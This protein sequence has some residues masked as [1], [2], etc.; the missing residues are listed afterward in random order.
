MT[1]R[2]RSEQAACHMLG[3]PYI[4]SDHSAAAAGGVL[5][6]P[7]KELSPLQQPLALTLP[8]AT[9]SLASIV[10]PVTIHSHDSAIKPKEAIPVQAQSHHSE[11][12]TENNNLHPDPPPRDTQDP[13]LYDPAFGEEWML[14]NDPTLYTS[15]FGEDW[16][17]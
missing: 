5:V 8:V 12:A 11:A 13:R 9:T 4:T 2:K 3:L 17:T 16:D 6:T 1:N 7:Y 14:E 10:D 15:A